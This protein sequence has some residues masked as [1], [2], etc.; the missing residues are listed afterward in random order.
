MEAD[1]SMNLRET[2]L[3]SPF[4]NIEGKSFISMFGIKLT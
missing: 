1:N 4:V 2:S 3:S